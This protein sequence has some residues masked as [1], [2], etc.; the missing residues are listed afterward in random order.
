MKKLIV[1]ASLFFVSSNA[2]SNNLVK[3]VNA[4][5]CN[6]ETRASSMVGGLYLTP[7]AITFN[8]FAGV[9]GETFETKTVEGPERFNMRKYDEKIITANTPGFGSLVLER[10]DHT[11]EGRSYRYQ[12]KL[13]VENLTSSEEGLLEKKVFLIH[14]NQAG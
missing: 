2:F 14:C 10:G 7:T 6:A 4:V 9:T 13:E 5:S 1:I 8:Y 11:F 12:G 3:R